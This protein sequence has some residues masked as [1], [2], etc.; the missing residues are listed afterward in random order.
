MEVS[1]QPSRAW[2]C[3]DRAYPPTAVSCPNVGVPN[4][5]CNVV[6]S[7]LSNRFMTSA[8]TETVRVPNVTAF[9]MLR[10]TLR[11]P[12]VRSSE[13]VR[14]AL[15]NVN[16]GAAVNAAALIQLVSR[17]SSDPLVARSTPET[18]FGRCVLPSRPELLFDCQTL[19]GKPF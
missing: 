13:N 2:N 6:K 12:G 4:C 15:P 16:A 3:T 1:Y 8:R 9:W 19:T 7:G 11:C 17:S 14:G 10:S 5:D 18:T